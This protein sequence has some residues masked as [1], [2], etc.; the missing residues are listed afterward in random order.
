M[1]TASHELR[2]DAGDVWSILQDPHGFALW[3]GGRD[4]ATIETGRWPE[5][6]C[7]IRHVAG[8]GPL[9]LPASTTVLEQVPGSFLRVHVQ[10]GHWAAT[11][12]GIRLAP[13]DG[14]T[15]VHVSE[16][17]AGGLRRRLP[18]GGATPFVSLR[19][20]TALRRLSAMAWA[21]LA[22]RDH[23]AAIDIVDGD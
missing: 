9:D 2:A 7:R 8:Q 15:T 4:R 1:G 12:V 3:V 21:R 23:D 19:D 20:G 18:V 11:E 5:P 22:L 17:L 6:G 14:H 13:D 16:R 10:V